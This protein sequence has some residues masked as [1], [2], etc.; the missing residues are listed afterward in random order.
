MAEK[1]RLGGLW[2]KTTPNGKQLWD[3]TFRVAEIQ[4][5]IAK[6]GGD[7]IQITVWRNSQ[8]EKRSERS[9]DASLVV[10][11][12][13]EAQQSSTPSTTAVPSEDEIPF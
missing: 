2:A 6:V 4:A 11:E 5:A 12:K 1:I 13:W 8:E 3:G 7:E 10:S 9:P